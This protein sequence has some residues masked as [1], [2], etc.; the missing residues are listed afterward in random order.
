MRKH[1]EKQ[2]T[3]VHC[4]HE[5]SIAPWAAREFAGVALPDRRLRQRLIRMTTQ[6]VDH[7]DASIPEACGDWAQAKAA[8]RF[9]ENA[10]VESQALL[11]AHQRATVERI[12]D[13]AC[14]L[15]PQDTTSLNYSGHPQTQGLGPIA[16]AVDGPQG[17]LLH[18]ALALTDGGQPLGVIGAKCWA[19][20]PADF[21][22]AGQR[23]ERGI[24][25]KESVKWLEGWRATEAV[26]RQVPSTQ[27]I[28]L[29]DREGDVYELML[30]AV[31]T[32]CP[33]ARLLVRCQ[34]PRKVQAAG[35]Q[36][37]IPSAWGAM[38]DCLAAQ[39]VAAR[40]SIQVPRHQDQPARPAE[41]EVRFCAVK[42]RPPKRQPH[43]PILPLNVVQAR[44][45]HPPE[46][47][48]AICWR[49][50]TT[51]P[52]TTAAEAI[53][54]VQWYAKRWQIE[55]FH[56]VL[57]SGCRIE[58][59]QF[60]TVGRLERMLAVYIVVAWR[61]LSLTM[62]AREHPDL[63]VSHWLQE[64]QWQ[65]LACWANQTST[66]PEQSPPVKVAVLWIAKLG[67]FLARKGDG[68]PG[69]ICLWRGLSRLKDITA[70]FML[71]I[72]NTSRNSCG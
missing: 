21:G 6:F 50:L 33:N 49:L 43:L 42:L 65:T 47:R 16:D 20:D 48:E 17:L 40:L 2:T 46:G 10:D 44:E 29:C 41:L 57:K 31:E 24:E 71:S 32:D 34:H 15:V 64:A 72:S 26:A 30:A 3:N 19:R 62:A 69:P 22:K 68:Q 51:A 23:Y 14:V 28:S 8:Y 66:P 59:R 53:R 61:I 37:P 58:Q 60:A 38:D 5:P 35:P 39:P 52:V 70:G 1:P 27:F 36:E 11:A 13:H 54:C 18:Q 63:P 56:K 55:V 9:F 12:R 67:G 45:P 25:D 4:H 7:P